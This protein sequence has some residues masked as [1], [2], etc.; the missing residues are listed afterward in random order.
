MKILGASSAEV[1]NAFREGR[2]TVAVYGLGK[3]GL[4]LAALF[5][6]KGAKVVGVDISEKVVE[7]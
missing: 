4:P 5:A 7:T 6:D 2:I 3:M 1:S